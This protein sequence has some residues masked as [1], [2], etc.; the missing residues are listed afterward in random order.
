VL[1]SG[2]STMTKK[3]EE[4]EGG[5]SRR[6]FL[7]Q[8]GTL[9]AGLA[10]GT[11]LAAAPSPGPGFIQTPHG[12]I[13]YSE[14]ELL[15]RKG[16]FE[17]SGDFLK[18]VAFPLGGIGTGCISL[19]G[20]GALV[21]WEIFN[22][23]NKGYQPNFTFLSLWAQPEGGAPV[24]RILEGRIPPHFQGPLHNP[25][26]VLYQGYGF[27]PRQVYASGLPRMEECR[28][29]GKFP[30]GLV[31]LQD[32]AMPVTA[33]LEG[34]SPFIP[35][36]DR[37]S[38]LPVAVVF[39]TLRNRS[40]AKLQAVL[41]ANLQNV[42][43]YP[44]LGGAVNRIV[45]EEKFT[46]LSLATAKHKP[47]SA[48]F[49][50]IA[51]AT[52]Q[53]VD[54]WQ[55]YWRAGDWG[56]FM[57]L[58]HFVNT[59]A[60]TG[61]YDNDQPSG[62]TDDRNAMAGSLGI[63]ADL[64]PGEER[65]IPL[66]LAWHVPNFEHYWGK[67]TTWTNYYATQWKDALD[68]ARYTVDNL[69]RLEAETRRFQETF[70]ASSVPGHVLEAISSQ[71][72]IL[73]SPTVSRLPDGTLYGFEG[74]HPNAGCCEGSCSHVWNYVQSV[75]YLFPALERSMR[76]ID[77]KYNLRESDG[78][79]TFRLPM[80]PGTFADHKFHAAADGQL[81]GVLRVYREWQACGD[82]RWLR[83]IWPKVKKALEYAWI[84]WDKDKDGLLEGIHHNTLDIEFHGPETMCGSMYLAALLAAERMAR[85]L[86]D[87]DSAREY[88]RVFESGS[89]KSDAE[90][91]N[92]EHYFQR[93]NPGDNAPFQVDRGCI[94]DQ[95][96]GQWYARMLE[97]GDVYKRENV[98]Q[99]LTSL[100]KYN[101]R[102]SFNE[103]LNTMRVF[104]LNDEHGML[105][106]SWPHGGRPDKPVIYADEC[107]IGFE[108]QVA[109]HMIYE[110][111]LLEGLALSKSV[112]DRHDGRRRN[113]YN[114]FECGSHYARSMSNYGL[115]LALSGFRY[116]AVE[117]RVH[118]DPRVSRE[119]FRCFFSVDAGW[120]LV[121]QQIDSGRQKVVVEV[122]KGRLPVSSL[123][124]PRPERAG[125]VA[126]RIGEESVP[127]TFIEAGQA[128]E[129]RPKD[130]VEVQPGRALEVTLQL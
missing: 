72:S 70:F 113:P 76:E 58:Q 31:E 71:L 20:Y 130:G 118:L 81:G 39:V 105:I 85:Y 19:S 94:I 33:A 124:L 1:F 75:A 109:S 110:G 97:L 67:K 96:I 108:Y 40:R 92:G 121:A 127:A 26:G 50:T 115:L 117:R 5:V 86:G 120:G 13:P 49:G 88:R 18:E 22:R 79:M 16:R 123:A 63:R 93:I 80:P 99:A 89:R 35:G 32:S 82:D 34:W 6:D 4:F 27:G 95:V 48:R 8:A 78:H 77:Y 51:L 128:V 90:L 12:R 47:D 116:S 74:C 55:T 103:H 66:I 30:F 68:V 11:P 21:D 59:F 53:A 9:S 37:E 64:G 69:S 2:E 7:V 104:A 17:Y 25:L 42:C 65:R 100:F 83:S 24:F 15:E 41:G 56:D 91:F 129:V 43:G 52:T 36:N 10:A 45:R 44:E 107:M 102:E 122:I 119:D 46:A 29:T 23:P 54:S 38:S 126:A 3:K 114:E 14:A 57:A 87:E 61:R 111:L 101:Y 106:C 28:F 98:R 73:R 62:P 112:R 84:A 125:R 60:R